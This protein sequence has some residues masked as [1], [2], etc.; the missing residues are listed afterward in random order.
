MEPFLHA[1][2]ALPTGLYSALLAL[3][4][5][6]WLFVILGFFDIDLFGADID[7]EGAPLWRGDT[8]AGMMA[9]LGLT[10]VPIA[11]IFSFVV[12]IAWLLSLLANLYLLPWL[13]GPFGGMAGLAVGIAAF[14]IALPLAGRAVVPLRPFFAVH[15]ADSKQTLVGKLCTLT[16]GSVGQTHGQA[17]YEQGGN[18]LILSVTCH[19]EENGLKR[20]DPLLIIDYDSAADTYAVAPYDG[21]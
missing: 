1:L 3:V 12:L 4:L 20:G 2:I 16:S 21:P 18:D 17:R 14:V 13:P 6:Y 5:I 9:A 11:I 15:G 10:G 7:L 8:L 19:I